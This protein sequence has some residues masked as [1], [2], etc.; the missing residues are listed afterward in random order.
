MARQYDMIVFGAS[1]FTGKH[2]ALELSNSFKI[3]G[4]TWAIA[5]RSESKLKNV[6]KKISGEIG[7]IGYLLVKNHSFRW[8]MGG[9]AF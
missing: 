5:G 6:L 7:M 2:V 4:K 8:K 3:E 9:F 1:G